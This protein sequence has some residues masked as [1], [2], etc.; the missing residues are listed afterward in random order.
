MTIHH[1]KLAYGKLA[2]T[3]ENLSEERLK[4]MLA[5]LNGGENPE[6]NVEEASVGQELPTAQALPN[7]EAQTSVNGAYS[8]P[9]YKKKCKK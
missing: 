6:E 5:E 4:Q 8:A 9:N 1:D 7:E 3:S 2:P